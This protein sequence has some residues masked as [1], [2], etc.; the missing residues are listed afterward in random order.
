MN[1]VKATKHQTEKKTIKL[2]QQSGLL[3]YPSLLK[4]YEDK[5]YQLR[6]LTAETEA[7]RQTYKQGMKKIE[8]LRE[9]IK[10]KTVQKYTFMGSSSCTSH[11]M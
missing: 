9:T 7:L 10:R 2:K 5:T 11:L 3:A 4:D 8:K 6:I 1:A